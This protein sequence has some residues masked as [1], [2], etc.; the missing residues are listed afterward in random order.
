MK[1]K[2]IIQKALSGIVAVVLIVSM[3]ASTV[4]PT[5]AK[6]TPERLDMF[7]QN[8]IMFYDPDDNEKAKN[9]CN[10]YGSTGDCYIA[11]STTEEKLWSALR[12]IGFT[13][14][15]TAG[16]LGNLVHE[17]GTP[18]R[19]E[20]VFNEARLKSE[21]CESINPVTKEHVPYDIYID[22]ADFSDS[23]GLVHDDCI[24]G[25][26]SWDPYAPGSTHQGVGVGFAGWTLRPRRLGYLKTMADL[27][28]SKYFDGDAYATW[29]NI[30]DDNELR[31][32]IKDATG[33]EDDY[34]A[35]WC[36]AIKFIWTE[37]SND[38]TG[39]FD[40]TSVEDYA[41]WDAVHYEGCS[42]CHV[43]G[44]QYY[45]R[46]ESAK[47]F[48]ERYENGE[49]DAVESGSL[50]SEFESM[51]DGGG[52]NVTIIG[53]SIT[54]DSMTAI[55]EK[56]PKVDII[57]Q[58]S[59]QFAGTDDFNPTGIQVL[60]DLVNN[61]ELRSRVVFALGTSGAT[62]S[63]SDI[64]TV[65][66]KVGPSKEIFFLTNLDISDTKKYE[67]NNDEFNGAAATYNNVKV[68]DWMGAVLSASGN[69][70]DY[71][72]DE[73][74]SAGYAIRPTDKGKELFAGLIKDAVNETD[75]QEVTVC[76]ETGT[77]GGVTG[78]GF[79]FYNQGAEP[80]GS[81]YYYTSDCYVTPER[82]TI[83]N[84]A[85]GAASL[86]MIITALTGK[87]ITPDIVADYARSG[88]HTNC[89]AGSWGTIAQIASDE[90]G[91]NVEYFYSGL[92]IDM[93]SDYLREG[94]MFQTS[95]AGST[96]FTSGGHFIGLRGITE[97]GKWLIFD[98]NNYDWLKGRYVSDDEVSSTNFTEW[99]PAAI[100]YAPDG[101]PRW[102]A[103]IS[104]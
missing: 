81:I 14:E 73:S 29:G 52:S 100:Y 60:D 28:L 86:A 11:G 7:A 15:Q 37:M 1:A 12:H 21:P 43:G 69:P 104:K 2:R 76:N 68:I 31:K 77:G 58:D 20:Q 89:G 61:N 92:T 25:L 50:P 82:G 34:W 39:F 101:S 3:V 96:P 75:K 79:T 74:E 47:E 83:A 38:Y 42:G 99:D 90:Y 26:V 93:I 16:V 24:L 54:K 49:F 67:D 102:F 33:S 95:G 84:T 48:Y 32:E 62:V 87:R 63:S 4:K 23:G 35:L 71:I 13:P 53:D 45:A 85:C 56:L 46:I 88:G 55:E 40:Q 57:A 22:T 18:V 97:D 65:V 9:L 8:D 72:V 51:S 5:Y 6:L 27:G 70:E 98:S 36:A 59:K 10:S 17:A 80:W 66:E 41:A 64:A 78:D 91:L 44:D 19:Q 103:K 94:A 30:A